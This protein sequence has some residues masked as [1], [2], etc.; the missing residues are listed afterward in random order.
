L[1]I[2]R[3]EVLKRDITYTKGKGK[4]EKKKKGR[5]KGN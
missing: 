5:K 1:E 4:K 2:H 3:L